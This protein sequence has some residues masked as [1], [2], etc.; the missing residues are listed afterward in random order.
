[1]S[2]NRPEIPEKIKREVRQRC[3]FGCVICGVPLYHYDHMTE[4]KVVREHAA[5]NITLLCGTHHDSKTR[6]QL[7]P[8]EVRRRNLNPHN[9]STN[10]TAVHQLFFSGN[11]ARIIA[12]GNTVHA[13]NHAASAIK[14]D[15]HSLVDFELV[16]G[17]LLL[18]VALRG[19]DGHPT[20]TVRRNEL[21]HST[22]FWD[23]EFKGKTLSIRNAEKSMELRMTFDAVNHQVA[24]EQGLVFHNG[25]DVLLDRHGLFI[26]NNRTRLSGTSISGFDT[27]ISIGENRGSPSAIVVDIPRGSYDRQA[28]V[29]WARSEMK[30]AASRPSVPSRATPATG[31]KPTWASIAFR[32]LPSSRSSCGF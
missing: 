29:A 11:H 30:R 22:H 7:P 23:Y 26:L 5:E 31:G 6:G 21:V 16:D 19:S 24:I 4:Y 28:A 13:T 18:N 27:A 14:I 25:V 12:G 17:H 2:P 3:G 10:Q 20:L 9:H 8:E 32:P 15:G 1:M